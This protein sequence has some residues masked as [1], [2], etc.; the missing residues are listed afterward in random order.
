MPEED[1]E[2]LASSSAFSTDLVSSPDV[3][4]FAASSSSTG[5]PALEFHAVHGDNIKLCRNK[6]VARRADSFC[7]ALAFSN[8]AV[9]VNEI[10]CMKIFETSNRWS[11][12]LRVG[13]TIH[14]PFF[15]CNFRYAC[16]DLTNKQ[17]NWVK[18]ISERYCEQN[19]QFHFF[20][21]Q[22]GEMFYGVNGKTKG[23]F[24]SG[25]DTS[26]PMW[27]VVDVYGNCT[28][29]EF[30][31]T[32]NI[33]IDDSSEMN[34]HSD[35]SMWKRDLANGI[36]TCK[37]LP[38]P[39][40]SLAKVIS[41]SGIFFG[42][43]PSVR[44]GSNIASSSCSSSLS[45]YGAS[46]N[47]ANAETARRFQPEGQTHSTV[48]KIKQRLKPPPPPQNERRTFF[49][50][51]FVASPVTASQPST[52]SSPLNASATYS[53]PE[54]R[55]QSSSTLDSAVFSNFEERAVTSSAET[56][57]CENLLGST[58][59]G[60]E[61]LKRQSAIH[62]LIYNSGFVVLGSQFHPLKFHHLTG[63]HITLHEYGTVATRDEAY[64]DHGYVF[65]QS[66]L[67]FNQTVVIQV[68]NVLENRDSGL[69]VGVTSANPDR[70][71]QECLPFDSDLLLDRPEYWVVSKEVIGKPKLHDELGFF[72]NRSGNYEQMFYVTTPRLRQAA[73]LGELGVVRNRLAPHLIAHVDQT[74]K[75]WLFFDL[76]G[77]TSSVKLIG[78][79]SGK[80][81]ASII[82]VVI[83]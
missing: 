27:V 37:P 19:N 41:P 60:Q 33:R 39:R 47:E 73:T 23:L 8:R 26:R 77:S 74:Q 72:L 48:V 58:L 45:R 55:S 35:L 20:I 66:P 68:L 57:L 21:N 38:A 70:L 46:Q 32:S 15:N 62:K 2:F 11:G 81:F 59:I 30:V 42:V 63:K 25:I 52:S 5:R 12:V 69:S 44:G 14:D 43:E 50:P 49:P 24:L 10:F 31:D 4:T 54:T 61:M 18:A 17:G 80:L 67:E 28:A 75:L 65:V 51:L 34:H 16:P 13:I 1:S 40:T 83:W 3:C 29:V 79:F 36:V 6:K 7:K 56:N 9:E 64:N 53:F 82:I 76:Y 22:E 71:R 78:K